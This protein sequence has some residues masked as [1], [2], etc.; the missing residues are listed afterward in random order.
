MKYLNLMALPAAVACFFLSGNN[1]AAAPALEQSSPGEQ[2]VAAAFDG[3]EGKVLALL[4]NGVDAN[5][6]V[7]T[8]LTAWH[9]AKIRGRDAL[10]ERLAQRGADAKLPFPSPEQ[11]IDWVVSRRVPAGAPGLALAVVREGRVVFKRGWGLACLDYDV[12][13][14]PATVF[15]VASVSKQFTAFAIALLA[16]QGKLSVD[17]D[18]R[19]YLPDMPDFKQ[20]VT[21]RHLL[22]HTS[23]MRDQWELLMLAGWRLDDVITQDDILGMLRRQRELNFPPGE[24]HL[25]CNSG[26]TLLAEV[27]GK[28][29]GKPFVEYM[30]D[31]VFQ[32]L[33]MTNTHFHLDHEQVVKN[34][35]Y[36]YNPAR[37]GGYRKSVLSYA[38]VGATSLFTTVEDLAKWIAN[39][40]QP[41]V[42]SAAVL[43]QMRERGKLNNG[44][45]INYG[46]GLVNSEFRKARVIE[47]SGGD[48]GYRSYLLWFPDHHLGVALLSNL[49]SMD[50]GGLAHLAAEAFLHSQLAAIPERKPAAERK[51]APDY[52]VT[53]AVLENYAGKYQGQSG[54]VI[55][56]VREGD[57]LK[58]DVRAGTMRRL[59]PSGRHEFLVAD[60]D[61][62]MVFE[63]A[64]SGKA[65]R[66]TLETDG[67]TRVYQRTKPEDMTPPILEDYVGSYHSDE[68]DLTCVLVVKAGQLT[69]QHRRHGELSLRTVSRDHF[70]SPD[71]G[72]IRFERNQD[73]KIS[74]FRLTGG[75]VRNVVFMRAPKVLL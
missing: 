69:V 2:L 22:Y 75:R 1:T 14:T 18:Y 53:P 65:S 40:E 3:A 5:A 28:V 71:L 41:T 73:G 20:T 46:F 21:L 16:D 45:E 48:A 64:E 34:M 57:Q 9:A 10:A 25:Y 44:K 72:T 11:T 15:H 50:V 7:G 47:H 49:G 35:A 70:G 61:G 23:G 67:E 17:D 32:P 58:G 63:M 36:S 59:I 38:N 68:L 12:P 51:P 39:F 31:Q 43:G 19:K 37:G 60:T 74:G 52:A 24:E 26:Y 55:S 66:Y 30:R 33:G 54:R 13:I 27:A 8:G 4:T 42:G 62:R 56:I 29:S 6:T